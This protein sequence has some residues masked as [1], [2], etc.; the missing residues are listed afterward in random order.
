MFRKKNPPDQNPNQQTPEKQL[1]KKVRE[2]HIRSKRMVNDVMAGEYQSAFK[3]RGME[4]DM[5]REYIEGDEPRLIDWNVTARMGHLYVRGYVEERELTIMF[6]V[7]I[8][9]SGVFG[10]VKYLKKE[11]AAELCAVLALN[12]IKKNDKVGLLLFTDQIELYVPPKKGKTHVLRII[13]ELLFHKPKHKGTSIKS[14]LEY[15]RRMQKKRVVVFLVS[16]FLDQAYFQ[17]MNIINKKHD[18]VA[19]EIVDPLEAKLPNIGL[20]ELED[21]ET[22]NR[23][24]VDT[25]NKSW[26]KQYQSVRNQFDE[27]KKV[28]FRKMK[29][30]HLLIHTNEPFE[31]EL[32][33]FFKRRGAKA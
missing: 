23:T 21:P 13:R 1:L 29:I 5:V 30:D 4:F 31:Q 16:D 10:S 2:I 3:G 8:S 25:S 18:L 6:L 20:V 33:S 9:A 24:V 22:G 32:V 19:V 27:R 17:S 28:E 7:D 15:F 26:R 12:A 14:A 11:V